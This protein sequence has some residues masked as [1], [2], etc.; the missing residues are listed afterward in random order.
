MK[1][2]PPAH[3]WKIDRDATTPEDEDHGKA[4]VSMALENS[5]GFSKRMQKPCFP[6]QSNPFQQTAW[7]KIDA[8]CSLKKLNNNLQAKTTPEVY[9]KT[10]YTADMCWPHDI[11]ICAFE[12]SSI[13][14][15]E[16]NEHKEVYSKYC[17]NSLLHQAH[18]ESPGC[19]PSAPF[20]EL[21][22][23]EGEWMEKSANK[24]WL[25]LLRW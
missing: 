6:D 23:T 17:S 19:R 5:S 21:S 8:I 4:M 16:K 3:C 15:E 18:L 14:N 24:K 9:G 11:S 1:H 12:M 25:H 13:S 20:V 2:C 22:A 7:P 10:Q